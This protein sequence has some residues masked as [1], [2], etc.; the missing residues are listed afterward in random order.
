MISGICQV[1]LKSKLQQTSV[2][3][4]LN[5]ILA[6]KIWV[7]LNFMTWKPTHLRNIDWAPAPYRTPVHTLKDP[8]MSTT[9]T[10]PALVGLREGLTS[11]S[12]EVTHP[13]VLAG[14]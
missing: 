14:L 10:S 8:A 13:M 2:I 9:D 6:G 7:A 3:S 4:R 12:L 5:L 1:R 11:W